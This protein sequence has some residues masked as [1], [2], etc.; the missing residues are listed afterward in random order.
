LIPLCLAIAGLPL[1]S[2][3]VPKAKDDVLTRVD[4]ASDTTL[5]KR[6]TEKTLVHEP[7]LVAYTNPEGWKAMPPH[8]MERTI[9][10]RISSKLEIEDTKR[11]LVA[12]LYWIQMTPTQNLSEFIRDMP[13]PGTGE[14]GEEYETLKT[15]YGKDHVTVPTKFKHGPFEVYR[16]YIYG[17]PERGE[18]YDGTLFVFEV[19]RDGKKWLVK[20]RVSFPKGERSVNDQYAMEVLQGYSLVPPDKVGSE[21]RRISN[22]D[23][24]KK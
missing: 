22:F 21:P 5:L 4:H 11:D 24:I 2:G 13:A 8:R 17:G 6:I 12:S 14:Y 20:A 18:K 19:E 15:I 9:D 23:E 7:T 3:Q 10:K 16:V 1:A